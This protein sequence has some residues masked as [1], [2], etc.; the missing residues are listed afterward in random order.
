ML[1]QMEIRCLDIPITTAATPTTAG[2]LRLSVPTHG[3]SC[4]SV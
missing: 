1:T 3:M 4:H 2:P